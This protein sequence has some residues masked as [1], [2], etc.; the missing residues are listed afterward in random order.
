MDRFDYIDG[1]L[2]CEQVLAESIA[3]AAGTPCYVY[4]RATLVDHYRRLADAF[5]PLDP[6]I[7][8]SIKSCANLSVWPDRSGCRV[9]DRNESAC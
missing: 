4:S 1:R 2:H 6:L 5:S 9:R 3:Q 8:Y 7:C